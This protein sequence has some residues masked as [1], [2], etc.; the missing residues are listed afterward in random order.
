MGWTDGIATRPAASTRR[1]ATRGS[2][3]CTHTCASITSKRAQ[4]LSTVD[5]AH[6]ECAELLF[7][8]V[9]CDGRLGRYCCF[10]RSC[11]RR[12]A[13]LHREPPLDLRI[14]RTRLYLLPPRPRPSR[15]VRC[16]R[17]AG[18]RNQEAPCHRLLRAGS[19][20]DP[21]FCAWPSRL[22]V[23]ALVAATTGFSRIK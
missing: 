18:R 20:H 5:A 22:N 7:Q 10:R 15:Q 14:A 4:D 3:R 11:D 8:V 16:A 23:C 9:T 1:T 13:D 2:A 19:D 17:K 6:L 21:S 12:G